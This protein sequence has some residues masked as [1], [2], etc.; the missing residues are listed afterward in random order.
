MRERE[1][2]GGGACMGAGAPRAR[3][4]DWA[5][6]GQAG[7]HRGSKPMTRTTTNRKPIANRN[8]KRDETNT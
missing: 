5:G 4:P 1:A 6:P 7:S 3:G 2:R 8:P